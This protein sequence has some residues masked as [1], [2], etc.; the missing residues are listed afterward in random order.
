VIHSLRAAAAD[1]GLISYGFDLP[2]VFRQAAV[3]ADRILKG[4]D[5]ADLS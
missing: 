1:G 5:P 3:Y 4:A 2:N